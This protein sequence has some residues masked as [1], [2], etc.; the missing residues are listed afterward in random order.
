M[1]DLPKNLNKSSSQEQKDF[2]YAGETE[3]EVVKVIKS[4]KNG[5]SLKRFSLPVEFY[6]TFSIGN[7][8]CK[9]SQFNFK[10]G[11]DFIDMA[12]SQVCNDIKA[13]HRPHSVHLSSSYISPKSKDMIFSL[14]FCQTELQFA[15]ILILIFPLPYG[16]YQI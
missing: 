8:S 16:R 5:K 1:R 7:S 11:Q 3:E 9:T 14:L 12:R 6:K 2:L 15:F 4:C 13:W 10:E